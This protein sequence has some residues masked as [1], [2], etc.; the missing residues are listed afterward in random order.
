MVDSWGESWSERVDGDE[1][2]D[3]GKEA[4]RHT[5]LPIIASVATESFD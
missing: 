5:I 1:G 2:G 3:E 4:R